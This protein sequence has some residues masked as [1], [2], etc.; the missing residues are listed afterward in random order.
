VISA[1]ETSDDLPIPEDPRQSPYKD[2]R[3]AHRPATGAPRHGG[4]SGT[5]KIVGMR[6]VAA[7]AQ[8]DEPVSEAL[9]RQLPIPVLRGFA[10]FAGDSVTCDRAKKIVDEHDAA[11]ARSAQSNDERDI[12]RSATQTAA[13]AARKAADADEKATSAKKAGRAPVSEALADAIAG[14]LVKREQKKAAK[15]S[16]KPFIKKKPAKMQHARV[17]PPHTHWHAIA[18]ISIV[19]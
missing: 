19:R 14:V 4:G 6:S 2:R 12:Q 18:T 11:A 9:L 13:R 8:T 16:K 5:A 1:F 15:A 17:Q 3:A 7:S 10:Q